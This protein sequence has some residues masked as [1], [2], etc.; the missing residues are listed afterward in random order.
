MTTAIEVTVVNAGSWTA[1]P[2][3][4]AQVLARARAGQVIA[5]PNGAPAVA[6]ALATVVNPSFWSAHFARTR[7]CARCPRVSARGG[8]GGRGRAPVADRLT[9]TVEE[10]AALLGIS[11]AF[12]YEA[13]RRGEI[14]SIRIGRRVLVPKVAL[15]RL[16]GSA[17]TPETSAD[18]PI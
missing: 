8:P 12:A 13:V 1:R 17:E 4:L 9:L 18:E 2:E 11:R 10:A 7:R 14:P 3:H 6:E 5:D 16:V 15:E